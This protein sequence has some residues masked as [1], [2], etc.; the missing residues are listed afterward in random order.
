MHGLTDVGAKWWVVMVGVLLAMTGCDQDQPEPCV[1]EIA[2]RM[3]DVAYDTTYVGTQAERRRLDLYLPPGDGP[4]PWIVYVHGGGYTKISPSRGET[5]ATALQA[6]GYAVAL[7]GYRLT[8]EGEV[9]EERKVRH[10]DHVRDLARG[11]RYLVDHADSLGLDP[12][13][14]AVMGHST[15]AALAAVLLTN[16]TFLDEVGL[17]T[18]TWKAGVLL[19]GQ[20]YRLDNFI[21]R[22]LPWVSPS[23]QATS[24]VIRTRTPSQP[25]EP[26]VGYTVEGPVYDHG[27]H[28]DPSLSGPWLYPALLSGPSEPEVYAP[29]HALNLSPYYNVL[30]GDPVA[31][32]LLVHGPADGRAE[33]TAEM[34][35][36][37]L[38]A[39]AEAAVLSTTLRHGEFV[40]RIGDRTGD[41][42]SFREHL[43][44]WLRP[45]LSPAPLV[46]SS[47]PAD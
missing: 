3:C 10:P 33:H 22:T 45:R 47:C 44:T 25:G 40:W 16:P 17:T 6:E 27:A 31:P 20:V 30:A 38:D 43:L 4:F 14:R 19:D 11:V 21:A 29:P 32:T 13:R 46:A 9:S 18:Q 41:G 37:Y 23:A 7:V 24:G 36:A 5:V 15:G 35:R 2:V 8:P 34:A 39:G 28:L 26:P 1:E 12:E 42:A